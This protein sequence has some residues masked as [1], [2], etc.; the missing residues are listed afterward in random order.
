[1]KV[2]SRGLGDHPSHRGSEDRCW[3]PGKKQGRKA[4][5]SLSFS[6]D[7][8]LQKWQEGGE[9]HPKDSGGSSHW[10]F[11]SLKLG[12]WVSGEVSEGSVKTLES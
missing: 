12:F 8:R 3:Q 5:A 10:G 7:Q 6:K 9:E 11:L 1:M 2:V 4:Q